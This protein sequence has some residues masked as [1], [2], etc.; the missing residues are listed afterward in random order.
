MKKIAA[1][2]MVELLL[3]MI[4]TI[5]VV[6]ISMAAYTIT[7]KMFVNYKNTQKELMDLVQADQLLSRDFSRARFIRYADQLH[8][9]LTMPDSTAI[10]YELNA[11]YLLRRISSATDTFQ[12]KITEPVFLFEDQQQHETG[13]PVNELRFL[14]TCSGEQQVMHYYK[15]YPADLIVNN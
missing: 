10:T 12:M 15:T 11:V 1:F 3:V 13:G 5:I 9:T 2:T 4:T 6:G 8:I 7:T 14:A